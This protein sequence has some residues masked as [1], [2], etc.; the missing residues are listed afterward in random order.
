MKYSGDLVLLAEGEAILQGV[1]ASLIEN[2]IWYGM[3]M[4]VQNIYGIE[5]LKTTISSTECD[6][7]KTTWECGI[8]QLFE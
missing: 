4:N 7:C 1:I 2:G 6:R 5:N 8:L 3:K